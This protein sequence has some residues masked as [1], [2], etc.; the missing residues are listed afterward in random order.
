MSAAVELDIRVEIPE[1]LKRLAA[2]NTRQIP[3]AMSL[4]LNRVTRNARQA[5]TEGIFRR[6][7]VRRAGRLRTS[8][9]MTASTKEQLQAKLTVADKFLIQHEEGGTRHQGDVYRSMVQPV[10]EREKRIGVVHGSNTPK[11]LLAKQV[12][13]KPFIARMRSGKVGVFVRRGKK[14]LPIDLIFAL[15]KQS[16]LRSRLKLGGTVG[17]VV[18]F[19][20]EREFGAALLKAIDSAR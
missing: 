7:K 11:A 20:W 17:T 18:A 15:E 4:A 16:K 19:E 8:V 3:F 1:Q 12:K 13:T 5:Q 14:R 2:A 6:F 10:R 9:R